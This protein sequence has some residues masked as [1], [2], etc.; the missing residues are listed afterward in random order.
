MLNIEKT[1]ENQFPA[2]FAGRR[3]HLTRP[4]SRSLGRWMGVD[5]ANS[6]LAEYGHLTGLSLVDEALRYFHCRYLVDDIEREHIPSSGRVIIAANHPLGGLDSLM[7]LKLVGDIRP[8]VKILA[9]DML[10]SIH[11]LQELFLPVR[12]LGDGKTTPA[13]GRR[14]IKAL[15]ADQALIIFPAGEVSRLSPRG[16]RDR[17]WHEG[18]LR[19]AAHT[20]APIVPVHVNA[21]NSP[22]FYAASMLSRPL[23]TMMLPR[24]M[25]RRRKLTRIQVR[26]GAPICAPGKHHG[27]DLQELSKRIRQRVYRLGRGKIDPQAM[28]VLGNAEDPRRLLAELQS[29]ERIGQTQDGKVIYVAQPG[30]D[31]ALMREIGR[32]RELTFRAVGE[33]TAKARDID[34]YDMHY[35]HLVLWDEDNLEVV[36]A[37]R[38]ACCKDVLAQHGLSGLYT[39]S[40]FNYS[41][42]MQNY[43]EHAVELGRS[44]V[45]PKYWGSRSL[46][47][48]WYG[49]GAYLKRYPH[50]RYLL[51]PV[52]I[53]GAEPAEAR[54]WLVAYYNRYF[55][56]DQAL[57]EARQPFA[58]EH[59]QQPDFGQ[60]DA[61]TSFKILKENLKRFGSR[62]P[63]LYKQYTE[64]CEPGGARFLAFGVDPDFSNSVDG[65]ILVNLES[66]RP[67]KRRRYLEGHGNIA[68]AQAQT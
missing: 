25:F 57:V 63:T 34:H 3:Q 36:G 28:P 14:I 12:I 15:N 45:Q 65:L 9:N 44:F 10:L 16:I 60:L 54:D 55:G 4:L 7:L 38:L 43:L 22:W 37:Y 11:Q 49:I 61:E 2:W 8:D 21:S 33:G 41:P 26:I 51:G 47:Y 20:G 39:A 53:S 68:L 46:D 64:L 1:L 59:E 56:T 27:A 62:V 23:G 31:S 32:L 50:L 5:N 40:L 24:Q 48:L 35:D 13:A 6:F 58:Y 42:A 66:I 18:F 17:R 67:N 29:A 52:T 19:F 30:S